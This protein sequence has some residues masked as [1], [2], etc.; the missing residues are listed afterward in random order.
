MKQKSIFKNYIFNVTLTILNLLFPI[1]TFPYVSRVL[2]ADGIGKVNFVNSVASYFVLFASLG[3]P[4]YGIR[5]IARFRDNRE[6][7]SKVFC[8]IFAINFISTI[9]CVVFYYISILS[10][11]AFDKER[12]LYIITGTLILLNMFN[13][14]WFYSGIEDYKFITIRSIIFKIVSIIM[15]FTLVHS[16]NNYV[17]YA[18]ITVIAAS[19]SNI[20]NMINC[21]KYVKFN[22]IKLN[23]KRHIK[24][25]IILFSTQF[26]I[27]IYVNLDSIMTGIIAGNASVGYYAAAIKINKMSLAIITALSSVLLPRLS[28]YIK[29]NMKKE[30]DS[31]ILKSIQV[32]LF[33]GIPMSLGVYMLAPEITLIFGGKEFIPTI[34]CLRLTVPIILAIA[35]G[36]FINIQILMPLGKEKLAFRAAIFGSIINLILNLILIPH[37]KQNGTSIATSITEMCVT[38]NM[39]LYSYSYIK[40]KIINKQNVK[41]LSASLFLILIITLTTKVFANNFL[42]ILVSIILSCISYFGILFMVKDKIINMIMCRFYKMKCKLLKKYKIS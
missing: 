31:L 14:D 20:V 42:I 13:I 36:Y 11:K 4:A 1:I 17:L 12:L 37:F 33:L 35:F 34:S 22:F 38:L 39:A 24:S 30:F 6:E 3:I 9:I 18:A 26:A 32:I 7:M 29:N 5:E 19:G 8:E 23:L 10:F 21:K 27:S 40:G 41:Y 25:I 16:K 2:G 15:L 28:Y